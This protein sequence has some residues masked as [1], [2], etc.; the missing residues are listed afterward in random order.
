MATSSGLT[1]I[2]AALAIEPG[3]ADPSFCI[4]GGARDELA[5]SVDTAAI[6]ERRMR[7]MADSPG[8]TRR[9]LPRNPDANDGCTRIHGPLVVAAEARRVSVS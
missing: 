3:G 4:A 8:T 2:S 9:R 1:R 7:N 6:I 5:P